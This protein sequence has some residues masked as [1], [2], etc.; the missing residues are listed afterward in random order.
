[1]DS[2]IHEELPVPVVAV[3]GHIRHKTV[4]NI[5]LDH[6]L[7]ARYPLE[8]LHK[9]GHRRIAFIKGQTFSSDKVSRRNATRETA[10]VNSPTMSARVRPAPRRLAAT[11]I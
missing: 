4:I 7:A 2:G 6:G 11:R 3:S 1:V 9:V 5:E 10:S 8:H